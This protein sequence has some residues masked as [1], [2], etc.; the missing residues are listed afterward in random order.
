[1]LE[2][3]AVV[4]AYN[5]AKEDFERISNNLLQFLKNQ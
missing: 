3:Y 5:S 4:E 2:A 1:M